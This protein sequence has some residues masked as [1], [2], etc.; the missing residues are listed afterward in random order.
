MVTEVCKGTIKKERV[1]G[2]LN[3]LAVSEFHAATIIADVIAAIDHECSGPFC[4]VRFRENFCALSKLCCNFLGYVLM[5]RVD[6]DHLHD[7]GVV[8]N[9]K[10]FSTR[11]IRIKTK[12]L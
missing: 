8:A 10:V 7:N 5:E 12:L 3:D 4:P 9:R 1:L 2:I 11:F 6:I